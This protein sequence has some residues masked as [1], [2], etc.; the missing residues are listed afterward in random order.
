MER[1]YAEDL[2]YW[3]TGKTDADTWIDKAEKLI[4]DYGGTVTHRA[5]AREHGREVILMRFTFGA[6]SFQSM[7]PVLE[8]RT[9]NRVAARRQAATMMH[10]DIKARAVRFR[11]F[12]ARIAFFDF[13][14][15]PDGRPVAQVALPE[16]ADALPKMLTGATS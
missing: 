10:H 5:T 14:V 1:E 15:L 9:E 2:P 8:S 3:K 11:I 7:W 6:D 4:E 16:I 13:L 12:G